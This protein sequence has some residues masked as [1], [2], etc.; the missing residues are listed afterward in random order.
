MKPILIAFLRTPDAGKATHWKA[1]LKAFKNSRPNEF[2]EIL[3]TAP[4]GGQPESE[5]IINAAFVKML[6]GMVESLRHF[7]FETAEEHVLSTRK[8]TIMLRGKIREAHWRELVNRAKE[9]APK[10]ITIIQ[11]YEPKT[12]TV[13]FVIR[14]KLE[15]ERTP[16]HSLKENLR[17]LELRALQT[18]TPLLARL[19]GA[20]VEGTAP[21]NYKFGQI[22][23]MVRATHEI[24]SVETTSAIGGT[25]YFKL[26]VKPK[27][28]NRKH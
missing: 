5:K 22:K 9:V 20:K 25:V 12:K 15:A 2:A 7:L 10:R 21:N 1:T 14:G 23:K 4:E 3:R 28:P 26:Q 18:E 16:P 13:H 11:H 24:L 17:R 19:I 27:K 6:F 8:G